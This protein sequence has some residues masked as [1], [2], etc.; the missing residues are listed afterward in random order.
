MNEFSLLFWIVSAAY[1]AVFAWFGNWDGCAGYLIL[2][3]FAFG[4]WAVTYK[5]KK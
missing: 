5:E 4:G 1:S 2:A 3:A